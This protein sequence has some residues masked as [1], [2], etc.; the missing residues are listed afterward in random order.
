MN[1]TLAYSELIFIRIRESSISYQAT[2]TSVATYYPIH[3]NSYRNHHFT[4]E[5]RH[6][7][8][9]E[10]FTFYIYVILY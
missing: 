1:L 5:L 7:V 3:T 2:T 9:L 4:D 10:W 6:I 8:C